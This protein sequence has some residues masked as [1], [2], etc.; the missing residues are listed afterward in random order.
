MTYLQVGNFEE[1]FRGVPQISCDV[2]Q[3]VKHVNLVTL[4]VV[5]T[6][7]HTPYYSAAEVRFAFP[8]R[9]LML[10]FPS[11]SSFDAMCWAISWERAMWSLC[12]RLSV[13]MELGHFGLSG[14]LCS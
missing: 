6:K 8:I 12:P 9:A 14:S 3:A 1:V 2:H 4:R 5:K 10:V 13:C 11:V 7:I